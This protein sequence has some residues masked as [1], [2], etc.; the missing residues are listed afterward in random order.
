MPAQASF[1][2]GGGEC[3][4]LMR[5]KD[6]SSTGLGPPGGWPQSLPADIGA[7]RAL[8]GSL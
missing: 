1:L 3:G 6:W 4:A 5:A 8:L 7:L 2:E